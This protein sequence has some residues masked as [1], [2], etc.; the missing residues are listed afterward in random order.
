MILGGRELALWT[1]RYSGLTL[2]LPVLCHCFATVLS[3]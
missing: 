2:H 1:G 3:R